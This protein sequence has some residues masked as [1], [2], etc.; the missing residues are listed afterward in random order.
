MNLFTMDPLCN[1][2]RPVAPL[3]TESAL[4]ADATIARPVSICRNNGHRQIPP[5]A[6]LLSV[7]PST[8]NL[9]CLMRMGMRMREEEEGYS[10]L[11]DV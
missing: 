4:A 6:A 11:K 5:Q 2:V 8:L 3:S 1:W 7:A 9:S 10:G